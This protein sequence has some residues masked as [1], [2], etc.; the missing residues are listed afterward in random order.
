MQTSSFGER[1]FSCKY[2][3]TSYNGPSET[4]SWFFINYFTSV[5]PFP[6]PSDS[7][8][9][10]YLILCIPVTFLSHE[11]QHEL[12]QTQGLQVHLS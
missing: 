4:N 11:L 3:E 10:S 7:I 12:P 8:F 9:S 5:A 1:S 2:D 6:S